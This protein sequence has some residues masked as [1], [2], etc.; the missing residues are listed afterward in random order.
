MQ[1]CPNQPD[2]IDEASVNSSSATLGSLIPIVMRI[3]HVET[4]SVPALAAKPIIDN[5]VPECDL[6]VVIA[7]VPV[8]G[9]TTTGNSTAEYSCE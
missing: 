1:K 7:C 2:H 9:D 3:K 5:S 4:A 8:F 6:A